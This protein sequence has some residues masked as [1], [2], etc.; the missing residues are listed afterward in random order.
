MPRAKAL[1]RRKPY[2]EMTLEDLRKLIKEYR[3]QTLVLKS[4]FE[5]IQKEYEDWEDRVA[6]LDKVISQAEEETGI[7]KEEIDIPPKQEL[8]FLDELLNGTSVD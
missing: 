3:E 8:S 7:T 1:P 2:E 5:R 4:N 6:E